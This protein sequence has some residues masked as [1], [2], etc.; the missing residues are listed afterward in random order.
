ML[1][2]SIKILNVNNIEGREMSNED[3]ILQKHILPFFQ[4]IEFKMLI[5]N[6]CV[7]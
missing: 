4:I 2:S 5:N 7:W 3:L 1:E 6:S